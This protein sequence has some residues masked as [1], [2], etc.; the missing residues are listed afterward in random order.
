MNLKELQE[1]RRQFKPDNSSLYISKLGSA[2]AVINGGQ[3]EL[4]SLQIRDFEDLSEDE[5]E[6]YTAM[7]KKALAGTLGKNLLE[8]HFRREAGNE[9]ETQQ[10]LYRINENG[11]KDEELFRQLALKILGEGGYENNAFLSIARCEYNV[12]LKSKSGDRSYEDGYNYHFLLA[13]V[14]DVKLSEIGL[15]FN[16]DAGQVE[17]KVNEDFCIVPA[18]EDG[19]LYPAFTHRAADVNH[20]LY[21]AKNAKKPNETLIENVFDC[22]LGLSAPDEAKN[23]TQVLQG[24]FNDTLPAETMTSLC[25][26]VREAIA[27]NETE[28]DHELLK[29]RKDQVKTLLLNAGADETKMEH[30]D[31]VYTLVMQDQPITAVNMIDPKKLA[32]TAPGISVTVKAGKENCFRTETINGR[33]VLVLDPEDGIEINGVPVKL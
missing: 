33:K 13:T 17:R 23:F 26:E 31:S 12:P 28:D 25:E 1:L 4:V 2:Y 29:L 14:H 18:P 32:V 3:K 24:V 15:F 6:L 30:F 10:L 5:N 20:L 11:L 8:L 21:R 9:N 19:F 16:K 27:E 22:P 7:M